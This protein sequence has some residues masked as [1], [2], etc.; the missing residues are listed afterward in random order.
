MKTFDMNALHARLVA[1]GLDA[2]ANALLALIEP[3]VRLTAAP[4][5]EADLPPGASKLGGCPD[6]PPDFHWPEYQGLP[7]SFLAQLDLGGLKG[8]AGAEVLPPAGLL[9]FFYDAEQRPWGFDPA[10]RDA[11][12][13]L[14]TPAGTPLTRAPF[15]EQLPEASR[16]RSCRLDAA[17]DFTFAPW[18][19]SDVTA[20]GLTLEQG[21]AYAHALD[22]TDVP[23]GTHRLLGH[24]DPVQGDMQLEAQLASHGIN[25]GTGAAEDD[26][27][28]DALRP[29]ATAWRLLLQ[30][31]SD[32]HAGMSWGDS[33]RI[34]FWMRREDL[35]GRRFDRA[36]FVLQCY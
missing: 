33:G 26:E 12:R 17:A 18:E 24:P 14:Y 20:L 5:S 9:S 7:Q 23:A 31:D 8:L 25:C 32:E 2:Q 4:A 13:V 15:P 6:V 36:W 28:V 16:F 21:G 30:L 19:S 1:G 34:Y 11:W 22:L 10:E 35:L 27:Q 3:S 29:G